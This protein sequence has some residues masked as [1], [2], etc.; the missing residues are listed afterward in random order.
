TKGEK[1]R[2]L[3]EYI[4]P[5]RRRRRLYHL[6]RLTG[7]ELA[8]GRIRS[9]DS[10]VVGSKCRKPVRHLLTSPCR[11]ISKRPFV[12]VRGCTIVGCRDESDSGIREHKTR[13]IVEG[14]G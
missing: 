5:A 2:V 9:R 7:R 6:Y 8:L 13:R 1:S 3:I 14:P 11:P 4:Y 10:H 12:R